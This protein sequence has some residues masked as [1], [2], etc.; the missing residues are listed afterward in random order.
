MTNSYENNLRSNSNNLVALKGDCGVRTSLI[1]WIVAD[2]AAL[3][4]FLLGVSILPGMPA[5]T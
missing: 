5:T 1:F 4:A 2:T 3:S